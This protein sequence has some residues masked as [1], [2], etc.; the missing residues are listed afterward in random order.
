MLKH[1][2]GYATLQ[3]TIVESIEVRGDYQPIKKPKLV[4]V[5]ARAPGFKQ[6]MEKTEKIKKDNEAAFL[7]IDAVKKP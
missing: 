2:F 3:K 4:I 5:L 7:A 1:R 6:L